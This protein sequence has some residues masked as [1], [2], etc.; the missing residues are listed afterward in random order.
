MPYYKDI[1]ILLIHIP[2][3]GGST[4]EAY[5]SKKCKQTLKGGFTNNFFPEESGFRKISLQHQTLGTIFKYR[6]LL[7]VNFNDK[8]QIIT[9]VRNPYNRIIS[10][11]FYQKL[12]E[13]DS[14]PDSVFNVI[15]KYIT[16]P[17][18]KYD[19]HNIPQHKFITDDAGNLVDVVKIFKTESLDDDMYNYGFLDFSNTRVENKGG[20]DQQTYANYLND[21]SIKLVNNFYKRDFELFN[22][23]MLANV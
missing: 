4:I 21:D 12:I 1:N 6:N 7:K 9:S 22:Y 10:D 23:E 17:P 5:L 18:S 11:L 16:E 13:K 19:N 8:L 2:K 15:Q 14:T 3:T 20:V